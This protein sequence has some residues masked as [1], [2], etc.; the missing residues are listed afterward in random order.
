M[1]TLLCRERPSIG[2][3]DAGTELTYLAPCRKSEQ[4][5]EFAP[6]KKNDCPCGTLF[7]VDLEL[8]PLVA[9]CVDALPTS[10]MTRWGILQ[11]PSLVCVAAWGGCQ[12][13]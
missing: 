12:T 6:P 7:V 3:S 8:Q 9:K 4:V 13:H 1:L 11:P 10:S 2:G 5:W